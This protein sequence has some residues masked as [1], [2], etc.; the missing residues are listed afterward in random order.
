MAGV[1]VGTESNA[2]TIRDGGR[3]RARPL[4]VAAV[5]AALVAAAP[6]ARAEGVEVLVT[7]RAGAYEVR[8]RFE[9]AARLD[10]V[11]EVLTD[12]A[13]IPSF[14]E[15]VKR[16]DVILRD[17]ARV[18]IR[19]V[20]SVG[21]F[22]L[23]RTARVMLEV[24]EHPRARI[25]FRDLLRENFHIYDGSWSLGGDSTRTVVSYALAASPRAGTPRWLGRSMLSHSAR[26]LLTQ[27][28]AEIE[29]RAATA[30]QRN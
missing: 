3:A 12:Y 21:V 13:H 16:S 24:R 6:A 4:R 2:G 11:W 27:V 14:V 28:R 9:T 29:R 22:P 25:E 30:P 7:N 1:R 17:S 8:G 20:A 5:L 19:Q 10:T 23:R 26:D 18:Q 15:S